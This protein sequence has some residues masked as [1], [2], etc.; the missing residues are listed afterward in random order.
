[1]KSCLCILLDGTELK[2]SKGN[3]NAVALTKAYG[4]LAPFAGSFEPTKEGYFSLAVRAETSKRASTPSSVK[5]CAC[6]LRLALAIASLETLAF[7]HLVGPG[8]N[9]QHALLVLTSR[10]RAPFVPYRSRSSKLRA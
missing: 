7:F 3:A 5:L 10:I 9:S 4:F 2:I 6:A 8:Q 1:M